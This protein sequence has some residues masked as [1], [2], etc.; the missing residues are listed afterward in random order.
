MTRIAKLGLLASLLLAATFFASAI[1]ASAQGG[2]P[3]SPTF[4]SSGCTVTVSFIA[5]AGAQPSS[6]Y[7][8]ELWDDG[9]KID[10][11]TASVPPGSPVT[12]AVTAPGPIKTAI[13]GVGVYLAEDGVYVFINDPYVG[14][15]STCTA[16]LFSCRVID[17][18]YQGLLTQDVQLFWA[19]SEDKPVT[20]TTV[21]KGGMVVSIIDANTPGWYK[22]AWA[23]GTYYIKIDGVVS[24]TAKITKPYLPGVPSTNK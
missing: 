1:P 18:G 13:A 8:L 4:S 9:S 20:P 12:L 7:T 14:I 16:G 5:A 2:T 15:D 6:T 24:N 23:C 22:I 17:G 19:A 11:V 21:I 10:S 3:S